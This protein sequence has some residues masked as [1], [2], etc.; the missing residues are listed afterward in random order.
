MSLANFIL[1][2]SIMASHVAGAIATPVEMAL[3]QPGKLLSMGHN[4]YVF[5]L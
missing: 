1:F 5:T 4:V 3:Q 2:K